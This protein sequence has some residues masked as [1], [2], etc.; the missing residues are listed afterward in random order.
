MLIGTNRCYFPMRQ[1]IQ[2]C[3]HFHQKRLFVSNFGGPVSS[4]NRMTAFMI[5]RGRCR[6][7]VISSLL[8]HR[9]F[10]LRIDFV[11]IGHAL[12]LPF[13]VT[14]RRRQRRIQACSVDYRRGGA[15]SCKT[16]AGFT[17]GLLPLP[18]AYPQ[19]GRELFY[20]LK[21]IFE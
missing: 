11:A 15:S 16:L 5:V 13:C 14:V 4:A 7:Y 9:E 17:H 2:I 6:D 3:G 18:P 20:V 19:V 1:V 21:N 8:N 12:S 10:T